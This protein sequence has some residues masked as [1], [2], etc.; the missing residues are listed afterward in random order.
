MLTHLP[1]VF[2]KSL[3][4]I[5]FGC[6]RERALK[7]PSSEIHIFNFVCLHC[8]DKTRVNLREKKAIKIVAIKVNLIFSLCLLL[9]P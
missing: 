9:V 4:D 2:S 7:I 8:A 6:A 3:P 1:N 5:S